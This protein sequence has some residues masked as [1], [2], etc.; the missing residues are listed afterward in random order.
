[1]ARLVTGLLLASR[2]WSGLFVRGL[3]TTATLTSPSWV[4]LLVTVPEML[5]SVPFVAMLHDFVTLMLGT[6]VVVQVTELELAVNALPQVGSTGL[7]VA[8][9]VSVKSPQVVGMKLPV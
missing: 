8:V 6:A 9:T 3:S 1:M 7:Q 4:P 2:H 5:T